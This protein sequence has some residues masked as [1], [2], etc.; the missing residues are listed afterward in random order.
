MMARMRSAG[1]PLGVVLAAVLL[2]I[3]AV[4]CGGTSDGKPAASTTQ[5]VS[6]TTASA[7]RC[8]RSDGNCLGALAP[9][10]Y[11]SSAFAVFGT[12]ERGHLAYSVADDFWANALDHPAGYWFQSAREYKASNGDATLAGVY[13][14][15]DAAAARQDYP[16]CGEAS[17][18]SVK[19]D[20]ASLITWIKHLP[21]VT[22]K[23]L[24]PV[25]T[26][27]G[28]AQGVSVVAKPGAKAAC[29]DGETVRTLIASRPKAWDPYIWGITKSDRIDAY[30][31]N[32]GGGHTVAILVYAPDRTAVP[33]ELSGSATRLISSFRFARTA[34]AK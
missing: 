34:N 18:T 4:G 1:H 2:C 30:F 8:L 31:Q 11:T 26:A 15:S 3:A 5:T 32:L 28:T 20:A 13:L 14:F 27:R 22:T 7:E 9:G 21:A 10:K 29:L 19:T 6:T 23:E 33:A 25:K 24:P 12:P 16:G 17:D